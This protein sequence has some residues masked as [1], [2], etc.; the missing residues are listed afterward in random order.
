MFPDSFC[1]KIT[2]KIYEDIYTLA[3]EQECVRIFNANIKDL[4]KFGENSIKID[5][6]INENNTS[7]EIKKESITV[8]DFSPINA[9]IKFRMANE[10]YLGKDYINENDLLLLINKNTL[11]IKKEREKLFKEL[12]VSVLN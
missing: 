8:L 11:D 10:G 3:F 6:K 2:K 1:S 12:R 9:N 4:I 7:L 5:V